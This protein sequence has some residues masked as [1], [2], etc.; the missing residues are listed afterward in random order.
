MW[1]FFC[2]YLHFFIQKI[3][4]VFIIRKVCLKFLSLCHVNKDKKQ[5]TLHE[6]YFLVVRIV[7]RIFFSFFKCLICYYILEML[8]KLFSNKTFFVLWSNTDCWKQKWTDVFKV[9]SGVYIILLCVFRTLMV[10][11]KL[12]AVLFIT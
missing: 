5:M 9:K 8:V 10:L 1:Y 11:V 2:L 7:Q 3:G 12:N 6:F 4:N